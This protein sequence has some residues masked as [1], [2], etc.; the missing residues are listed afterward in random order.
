MGQ[1]IDVDEVAAGTDIILVL[2]SPVLGP[3]TPTPKPKPKPML[4]G[5]TIVKSSACFLWFIE[6]CS[7]RTVRGVLHAVLVSQSVPDTVLIRAN[8][9]NSRAVATQLPVLP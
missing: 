8:E 7:F 2:C 4:H 5:P 1:I 3:H 9:G 6:R